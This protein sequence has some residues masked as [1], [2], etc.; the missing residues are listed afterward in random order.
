MDGRIAWNKLI[1][2]PARIRSIAARDYA[3]TV[4]S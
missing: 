2:A 4:N 1:A 3:K